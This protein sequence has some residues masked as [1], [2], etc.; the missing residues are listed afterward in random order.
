M[1]FSDA[2]RGI[3]ESTI[4]PYLE[5]AEEL[6]CLLPASEGPA[7]KR[8]DFI[9]SLKGWDLLYKSHLIGVTDRRVIILPLGRSWAVR[10]SPT[11]SAR[12]DVTLIARRSLVSEWT[13]LEITLRS[14]ETRRL[15]V[16]PSWEREANELIE[17]LGGTV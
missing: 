15:Y 11:S 5:G 16:D 4:R 9:T 17:V 14:G 3:L 12:M 6:V 1:K 2:V 7:V 8:M 10:G 13:Y